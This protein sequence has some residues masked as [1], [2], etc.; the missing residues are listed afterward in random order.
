MGFFADAKE[1][2]KNLKLTTTN[3]LSE[4]Y[5]EIGHKLGFEVR[6]KSIECF[7]VRQREWEIVS[8]S[9]TWFNR[10][11]NKREL[12]LLCRWITNG[13]K[14]DKT[15]QFCKDFAEGFLAGYKP[16]EGH[17]YKFDPM[18]D[19]KKSKY[20]KNGFDMTLHYVGESKRK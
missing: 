7:V 19:L 17:L 5:E 15:K 4:D 10:S 3:S 1:S 13:D 2:F 9:T 20:D 12:D 16:G 6:I 14:S 18:N 11:Q 8:V